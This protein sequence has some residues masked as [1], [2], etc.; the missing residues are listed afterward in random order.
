MDNKMYTINTDVLKG[1]WN[2]FK[3]NIR[4]QWGKLTED[5]ITRINGDYDQLVGKLQ[6]NYGYSRERAEQE[7]NKYFGSPHLSS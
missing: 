1:K 3:G 6:E 7:I 4:Q 2:Q 5:D